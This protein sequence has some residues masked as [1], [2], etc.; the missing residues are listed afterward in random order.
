MEVSTGD[1]WGEFMAFIVSKLE[2]LGDGTSCTKNP[3]HNMN[4]G[5]DYSKSSLQGSLPRRA[6]IEVGKDSEDPQY[7]GMLKSKA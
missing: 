6:V 7:V 2:V 1:G 5:T 3:R 4:V